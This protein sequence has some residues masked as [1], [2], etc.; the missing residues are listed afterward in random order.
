M[1]LLETSK[2]RDLQWR[3]LLLRHKPLQREYQT[4]TMLFWHINP[5]GPLELERLQPLLKLRNCCINQNY[6]WRISKWS[7]LQ[8]VGSTA[9]CGWI[10][11]GRAS[12]KPEFVDIIKS[13]MVKKSA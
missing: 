2:N 5:F 7:Q 12:L 9:R 11:V 10:L 1:S 4:G 13:V 8:R 6:L 3:L